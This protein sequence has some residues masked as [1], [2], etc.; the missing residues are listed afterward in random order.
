MPIAMHHVSAANVIT[1]IV[2]IKPLS[3]V[4]VVDWLL[5][6]SRLI[7]QGHELLRPAHRVSRAPVTDVVLC[8]SR[9]RITDDTKS[10]DQKTEID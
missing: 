7:F 5:R 10:T 4:R 1:C 2:N 8:D 6:R 9:A 3:D